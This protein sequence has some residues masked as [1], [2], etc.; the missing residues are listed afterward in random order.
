MLRKQEEITQG[1]KDAARAAS[2]DLREV[3]R[4]SS[5]LKDASGRTLQDG[6]VVGQQ[7]SFAEAVLE[8]KRVTGVLN[9]TAWQRAGLST[10]AVSNN[11]LSATRSVQTSLSEIL[12]GLE[13]VLTDNRP[14]RIDEGP[15][16]VT[17]IAGEEVLNAGAL[18][19][20]LIQNVE[21]L[22][23]TFPG[24]LTFPKDGSVYDGGE[25]ALVAAQ[26][27][28]ANQAREQARAAAESAE[29]L[30]A[31]LDQELAAARSDRAALSS[32]GSEHRTEL[33]GLVSELE[34]LRDRAN[35]AAGQLESDESRVKDLTGRIEQLAADGGE[36]HASIAEF[37]G[38]LERIRDR[39]AA[40]EKRAD[41]AYESHAGYI[42][43]V[44][45]LIAQAEKMVSG[46]T[47]AGLAR[48]FGDE[49]QSLERGMKG[50]IISFF[51]G[52]AFIFL[53]TL[54]LAA[55]V[56]E[57]PFEIAGIKLSGEGA[58]S[59]MGDEVTIAGVLSRTIILLAPFWLTLFS[60]RRYRNL[61]DLRQQYSHKYNMAFSVDGF[62]QQA[63]DYEQQIAA[64]VFHAVSEP[65][66]TNRT[67]GGA[68]DENPMSRLQDIVSMPGERFKQLL[69]A[70]GGA[71]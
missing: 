69:D 56:F 42:E 54:L 35:S 39:L 46:A 43:K 29:S 33:A 15:R 17:T 21:A 18:A 25:L 52:I 44:E 26:A 64:W 47:V 68:M 67:K 66:V 2:A 58:T 36:K 70:K 6:D 51:I 65:P 23:S 14:W 37:A 28:S 41:T 5:S 32:E 31:E 60:A 49:R 24:F 10:V 53:V 63:P 4:L 62:K 11:V 7:F 8:A 71:E 45:D 55:Y 61:F 16:V 27:A 48:A 9:R 30:R 40:T 20:N 34:G 3:E 19:T 50:A 1:I 59:A 22:K 12:Q 57:I 13:G 38:D